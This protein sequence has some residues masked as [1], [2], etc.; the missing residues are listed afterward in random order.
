MFRLY[1]TCR[2]SI[3]HLKRKEKKPTLNASRNGKS[4]WPVKHRQP[5]KQE[6][7]LTNLIGIFCITKFSI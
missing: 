4:L 2:S 7:G 3:L 1:V 5:K 6:T